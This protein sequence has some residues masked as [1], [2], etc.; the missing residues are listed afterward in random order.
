MEQQD[1][2]KEFH[3]KLRAEF[4]RIDKLWEQFQRHFIREQLLIAN[5]HPDFNLPKDELNKVLKQYAGH[6]FGCADSV[7]DKDENYNEIRLALELESITRSTNKY[8]LRFRESQLARQTH[9]K[10]KE[11]LIQFFP[12]LMELSANGFRLLEKY[13]L[14][15]NLE[16]TSALEENKTAFG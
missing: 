6:L 8:P 13:C 12:E 11:L 4:K 7:A 10:A 9:K 1:F 15:Y 16:F 2:N 5:E 14:F 3:L